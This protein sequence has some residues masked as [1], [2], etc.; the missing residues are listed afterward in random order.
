MLVVRSI[1]NNRHCLFL[2]SNNIE[3][4]IFK[5]KKTFRHSFVRCPKF[6][7]LLLLKR[8]NTLRPD[9]SIKHVFFFKDSMG[10]SS[11]CATEVP[12]C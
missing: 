2:L 8:P 12:G 5:G 10:P 6:Y 4:Y 11:F 9:F 7:I 3:K 1:N